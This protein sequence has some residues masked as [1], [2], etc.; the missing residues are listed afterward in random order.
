[1]SAMKWA[2]AAGFL[3]AALPLT[4]ANSVPAD[5]E[6][7]ADVTVEQVFALIAQAK[8]T[9]K[10]VNLAGHSLKNLDLTHADLAG[11]NLT[12]CNLFGVKF[13]GANLSGA[14]LRDANLNLAWL[15]HANFTGANL[16]GASL[17]APVVAEGLT[18]KPGEVPNF[19]GATLKDARIQARFTGSDM[20]GAN[21]SRSD[22]SAHMNNQSMGLM[23][24][25]MGSAD[26]EGAD[27]ANTNL[28]HAILTFADLR[29]ANFSGADLTEADLTG[30]DATGANFKG[31]NLTGT[32]LNG[33]K[34]LGAGG[35]DTAKGGPSTR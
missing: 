31:A 19:T 21:F 5:Q 1:M 4:R 26:L 3:L 8:Q 6:K 22:M 2:L 23:R 28:G 30:A 7:P 27:F 24:T 15:I 11:A 33:T 32:L 34:L 20:R 14:D 16:T 9:H 18:V 25:E 17:V 12:G 10:G 29:G 35:L 13:E